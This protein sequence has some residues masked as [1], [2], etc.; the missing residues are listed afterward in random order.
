MQQP[1][2]MTVSGVKGCKFIH[3]NEQAVIIT[4][5]ILVMHYG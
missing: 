2:W 5:Q 3:N 4:E 1:T